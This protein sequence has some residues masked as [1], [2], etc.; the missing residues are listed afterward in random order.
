MTKHLIV[1]NLVCSGC[2]S[3]MINCSQFHEGYSSH[4]SARI[5]VT[6]EPFLGIHEIAY[7]HQC[8]DA[9]CAVNCPSGAISFNEENG[10]YE[11]DYDLCIQCLTCVDTCPFEAVFF[12]K[13]LERI[14]KCNLCKG[15]P[16][17]VK[18]CFTGALLFK[19]DDKEHDKLTSRYF[20]EEK[21]KRRGNNNGC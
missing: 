10:S 18:S 20:L 1:D 17:C 4:E 14:I 11:I 6:L 12:D 9:E 8:D 7:C 15:E 2:M 21:L 5:K 3:C 13:L 16:N 19:D